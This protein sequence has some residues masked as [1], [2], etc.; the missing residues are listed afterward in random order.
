MSEV[1]FE[2][3][4]NMPVFGGLSNGTLKML[5]DQSDIASVAAGEFYFREGDRAQ[6]LFVLQQGVALVE[7]VW[8]DASVVLGR[9]RKGDCVG[10]MSLIDMMPRSASVRAE[11]DC[12]AIEITLRCLH[13]LYKQA[14]DQYAMIMMNMGREISRRLRISDDRLFVLEQKTTAVNS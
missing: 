6:S 5:L 1:D 8:K 2:L 9:L 10:E 12:Q 3:M 11:E 14:L 13:Q 7:R 4:R